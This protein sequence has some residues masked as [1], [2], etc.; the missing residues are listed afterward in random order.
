MNDIRIRQYVDDIFKNVKMTDTVMEQKEE[1]TVNITERVRDYMREGLSFDTAFETAKT[2][3]GDTEELTAPFEKIRPAE[4]G[5]QNAPRLNNDT[6]ATET[7]GNAAAYG[8]APA[9]G[10]FFSGLSHQFSSWQLT[11]LAPFIYLGLGFAFGWWAWAWVVIPLSAILC[12]PIPLWSKM[13]AISPF[14]YVLLGF[15]FGWWAWGWIIIPVSGIMTSFGRKR[16]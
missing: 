13:P 3:V 7:S 8:G 16:T 15:F 4:V 12:S 14:I 11:A 10:G 5:M 6:A 2:I 9:A 1:L